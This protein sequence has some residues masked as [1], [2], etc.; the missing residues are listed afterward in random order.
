[1]EKT[2]NAIK[3]LLKTGMK[4]VE[5]VKDDGKVDLSESMGIA[6]SAVGL[7]SVFKNIPEIKEE[8]KNATPEQIATVVADFKAE[9][10][11]PNDEAEKIVETGVEILTNLA[12]LIFKK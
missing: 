10:D 9:F 7:V 3:V 6:I 1:M 4:V 12:V 2:K 5:A 11:L 8:I